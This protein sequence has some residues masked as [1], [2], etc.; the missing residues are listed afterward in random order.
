M[1]QQFTR[2]GHMLKGLPLKGAQYPQ[3]EENEEYSCHHKCSLRLPTW[4]SKAC[5]MTAI[6]QKTCRERVKKQLDP[7]RHGLAGRYLPRSPVARKSAGD[8]P[9]ALS[10]MNG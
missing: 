10:Q 4:Y 1:R 6:E 2:S 8:P 7:I 9:V 5:I 3:T